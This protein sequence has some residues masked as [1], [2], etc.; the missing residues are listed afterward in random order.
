MLAAGQIFKCWLYLLRYP[1]CCRG[2]WSL[3]CANLDYLLVMASGQG[4][5]SLCPCG[6]CRTQN[7]AEPGPMICRLTGAGSWGMQHCEVEKAQE[8]VL[9]VREHHGP[10]W[11]K[12]KRLERQMWGAE[13]WPCCASRTTALASSSAASCWICGHRASCP[14]GLSS[15]ILLVQMPHQHCAQDAGRS[16]TAD[17][18]KTKLLEL[19]PNSLNCSRSGR[20]T[21]PAATLP[22]EHGVQPSGLAA[23]RPVTSLLCRVTANWHTA[24]HSKVSSEAASPRP[25]GS[26]SHS[27]APAL[28]QSSGSASP[29]ASPHSASPSLACRPPPQPSAPDGGAH[30]YI[31]GHPGIAAV[32]TDNIRSGTFKIKLNST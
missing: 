6:C 23:L 11:A 8:V 10:G 15:Q 20:S 13:D 3:S 2:D 14:Q 22:F 21:C 12:G 7:H 16:P 32:W 29:A 25:S 19:S 26:F 27:C 24:R 5:Y 18:S 28:N 31:L 4:A 1:V 30:V 9:C 17:G